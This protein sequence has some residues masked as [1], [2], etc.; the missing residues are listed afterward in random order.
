MYP[1]Y[2]IVRDYQNVACGGGSGP[3]YEYTNNRLLSNGYQLIDIDAYDYNYPKGVTL[4]T[5]GNI[6]ADLVAV[7][8]R[9]YTNG[10]L[11]DF[12]VQGYLYRSEKFDSVPFQRASYN[13]PEIGFN[14]I[15]PD[16]LNKL[17]FFRDTILAFSNYYADFPWQE[18]A[19]I[20]TPPG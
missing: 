12:T 2:Y 18:V 20:S 8:R 4:T 7:T 6:N 1:L 15:A 14:P 19:A 11:S 17:N 16:G 10:V 3:L 5:N 13:N 9:S